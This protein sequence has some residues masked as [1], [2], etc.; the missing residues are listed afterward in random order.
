LFKEE[1]GKKMEPIEEVVM[2]IDLDVSNM[3]MDKMKLRGATLM[4][5]KELSA[6]KARLLYHCPSR[7]LMGYRSEFKMDTKGTGIMYSVYHSHKEYVKEDISGPS[8]GAIIATDAGESTAYALETIQTRGVLF[9]EAGSTVYEGMIIGEHNRP[10][11][12][13]VNP[14]KKKHLSN[15]RAVMK[16]DQVRLTAPRISTALFVQSY[17]L[18]V[19]WN[20]YCISPLLF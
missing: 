9:I 4:D 2:E 8:R 14:C 19:P 10:E 20:I 17:V 12:L 13:A 7:T 18:T 15:V 1:N 5:F 16:E 3:I 6:T 11:D